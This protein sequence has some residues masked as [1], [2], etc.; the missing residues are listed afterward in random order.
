VNAFPGVVTAFVGSNGQG[1]NCLMG[2]S[3]EFLIFFSR[4]RGPG[5][6][7]PDVSLFPHAPSIR[8][9]GVLVGRW[10]GC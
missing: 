7:T 5:V 10:S 4:S 2:C 6:P 8:M 1:A 3:T 9:F